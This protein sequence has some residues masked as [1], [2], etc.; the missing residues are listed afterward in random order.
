M[1]CQE[2]VENL[3]AFLDAELDWPERERADA[4][5]SGCGKCAAYLGGYVQT[6]KLA[7]DV[8]R[9]EANPQ[10]ISENLVRRILAARRR[11]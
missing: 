3:Q 6:V 2:F 10:R 7:R 4:H 11:S 9:G 8:G 1:T 5:V